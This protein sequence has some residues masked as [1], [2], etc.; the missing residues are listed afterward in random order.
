VAVAP[1]LGQGH[2]H[3]DA[4]RSAF[5]RR[6]VSCHHGDLQ[7]LVRPHAGDRARRHRTDGCDPPPAL[8]RV[9]THRAG[10]RRDR[11]AIREVG[12]TA[13]GVFAAAITAVEAGAVAVVD[14]RVQPGYT[15]AMASALTRSPQ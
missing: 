12:R 10:P 5:Q 7:C 11:P 1:G 14:V 13:V 2:R 4:G 6:A 15:P 8:D 9:D 3:P